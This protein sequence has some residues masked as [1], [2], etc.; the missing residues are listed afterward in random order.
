MEDSTCENAVEESISSLLFSNELR[1]E[2]TEDG[3]DGSCK[4]IVNN[5]VTVL[6]I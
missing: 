3:E 2:V 5:G 6:F 1:N 4:D